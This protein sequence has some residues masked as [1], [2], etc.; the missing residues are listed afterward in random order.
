M[1]SKGPA[2]EVPN[3][4]SQRPN[5]DRPHGDIAHDNPGARTSH[6]TPSASLDHARDPS[7]PSCQPNLSTAGGTTTRARSLA[8][9]ANRNSPARTAGQQRGREPEDRSSSGRAKPAGG[10]LMWPRVAGTITRGWRRCERDR[11]QGTSALGQAAG[12]PACRPGSVH[13]LARAGGHPSG[14]AVAGS[15]VRSTREHRAGRPQALAQA[16]R[17]EERA[18]LLTLL[19]VGFTKPPQSPAAL[20]VSYT[21]SSHPV[22]CTDGTRR[23][24]SPSIVRRRSATPLPRSSPEESTFSMSPD[25][26]AAGLGRQPR[27]STRSCGRLAPGLDLLNAMNHSRIP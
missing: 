19:R 11:S 18:A 1:S 8:R 7:T 12:E 16:P 20:V 15:L 21:T 10:A 27:G 17:P 14:T 9:A 26:P 24:F 13:P 6:Q 25:N 22:T 2:R 4:G 23:P 3:L 5:H